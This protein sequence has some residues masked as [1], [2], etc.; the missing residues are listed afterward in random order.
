M[1]ISMEHNEK[2]AQSYNERLFGRGFRKALHEARF[3]WLSKTIKNLQIPC[4]SVLE[5]GCFD[6]KVLD[7]LPTRPARYAGFD[8]NWEGGLDLA[9]QRWRGN[10]SYSFSEIDMPSQM[11]LNDELFDVSIAMETLEH[12]SP[13]LVAGYLKKM[14]EHTRRYVFITVP[15]EKGLVFL[16]KWLVKKCFMSRAEQYSINELVNSTIGRCH[17]VSRKEHKGF[18]Y[19][20][21]LSEVKK[22][23]EIVH[24]VGIPN[25]FLPLSL[26]FGVG[27]VARKKTSDG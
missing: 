25:N 4:D 11:L 14:N 26:N 9:K 17:L 8:A 19:H 27:I 20:D 7:F 13:E 24:I 2:P 22:E 16:A 21:L 23:F 12:V 3:H 10:P 5:L 18:D 15:N 1:K 6:G